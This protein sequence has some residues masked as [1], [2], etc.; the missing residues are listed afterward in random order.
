MSEQENKLEQR[1]RAVEEIA[2]RLGV[3][4]ERGKRFADLT[5]LRVGGAIDWVITPDTEEQA[6]LQRAETLRRAISELQ[7]RHE[8]QDL[9]RQTASFG[10]AVFPL[11]GKREPELMR[12]ADE[13]LY[14]AKEQGRD[15][16]VLASVPQT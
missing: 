11:H 1:D 2:A 7:L 4:A 10:V 6:A 16:V 15:R 5:S 3:R 12:A 9:G 13:A 8:G 14:S